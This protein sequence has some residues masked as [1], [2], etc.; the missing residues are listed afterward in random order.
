SKEIEARVIHL[1]PI[2]I[3]ANRPR[4]PGERNREG[5]RCGAIRR[6]KGHIAD[7]EGVEDMRCTALVRQ[8]IIADPYEHSAIRRLAGVFI[9]DTVP[10]E[11][12]GAG[13]AWP[14]SEAIN[15]A[16]VG[17]RRSYVAGAAACRAATAP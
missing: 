5:S 16:A 6:S 14:G 11:V 4:R 17:R 3:A 7:I 12:V 2:V 8:Q 13:N 15:A 10:R 9:D 1:P